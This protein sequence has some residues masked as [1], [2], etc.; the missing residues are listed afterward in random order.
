MDEIK[1]L[2]SNA[3]DL[4]EQNNRGVQLGCYSVALVGLSIAIRRVRPFSRFRRPSDIPNHFIQER[5]ELTGVVERIEPSGALLMIRH[6]PLIA[7]PGLPE[8]QLPV[9]ISGVNVSGLG[10]NWLQAIVAG[11]E[12]RFIPVAKDRDF[13][14]C[15]VL[16]SQIQNNKPR[17]VNVGESLVRIGFGQVVDVDKPIS[18]DRTFLAYY[19]RLQGAEKYAK[20]KKMG[21]K[22]YINPTKSALV[23]A[24]KSLN[25][26]VLS[27]YRHI[28]HIPKMPAS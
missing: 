5:K 10:L 1:I 21:L 13:V 14:Q 15:E 19:H 6:K 28:V 18:S 26:M 16:L 7:L 20:R 8:G 24:A 11:S 2:L 9:K 4:M 12:V 17:V 23:L 22:Y 25:S 27:T 3:I